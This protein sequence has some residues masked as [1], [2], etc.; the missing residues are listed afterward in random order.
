MQVERFI[1]NKSRRIAPANQ[2]NETGKPP[3][4]QM[5]SLFDQTNSLFSERTGNHV[6]DT[7]ITARIDAECR[8]KALKWSG[9]FENS[10]LISLFSGN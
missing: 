2:L 9:K 8:Q 4:I 6:Q 3:F 1:K 10:L 5:N 7:G